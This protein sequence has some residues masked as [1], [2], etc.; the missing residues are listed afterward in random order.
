MDDSGLT[1]TALALGGLGG[2]DVAGVRLVPAN[3]A[4]TGLTEPLGGTTISLDFGHDAY[5]LRFVLR[6]ET[7]VSV[8]RQGRPGDADIYLDWITSW[9][10]LPWS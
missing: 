2:Q 5:L 8:Q 10:Q 7:T 6:S 1:Q 9:G 4:G 3:L